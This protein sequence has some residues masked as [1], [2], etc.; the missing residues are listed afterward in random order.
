MHK[1]KLSTCFSIV[2]IYYMKYNVF[3]GDIYEIEYS[4]F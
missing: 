2:F 1:I 4:I 3:K